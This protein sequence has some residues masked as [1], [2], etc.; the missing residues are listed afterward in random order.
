MWHI[1]GNASAATAA[2]TDQTVL[3]QM[4]QAEF[5]SATEVIMRFGFVSAAGV[6]LSAHTG[7][8]IG[9]AWAAVYLA[10]QG[11]HYGFLAWCRGPE[12]PWQVVVSHIGYALRTLV[13]VSLPLWLMTRPDT[14]LIMAGALGLSALVVFLLWRKP[15]P[16]S[17]LPIDVA[18]HGLILT[19]LLWH[20]LP[21]AAELSAKIAIAVSA[22]AQMT[23]FAMALY[24]TTDMRQRLSDA[25]KRGVEAEKLQAIGQ[26]SSGIAHD[27]NNILTVIRGNL[28][29]HAEVT[30]PE[31]RD[32]LIGD[33]QLAAVRA[34]TLVAQLLSF[35]R[36]A[37]LLPVD[38][39][40]HAVIAEIA[41][42]AARLLPPGISVLT[43]GMD[44]PMTL[45]VDADRLNA[46]LLNLVLNARDAINE[47]RP[48]TG[49][50]VISADTVDAAMV[51][52]VPRSLGHGPHIRFAV[53][54][55]G[56]GM[57]AEQ[58]S[59][60]VEPFFTTKPVGKGSGLGLA[61]AKS[62]AEQSG[63]AMTITSRPGRTVVA[64]YLPSTPA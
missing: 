43:E 63:G 47:T 14:A 5:A 35:S 56:P 23:Y 62:F 28:E 25:A 26:L 57:T 54:D 29:L 27:F 15:P 33:A 40:A 8:A 61:S 59:R 46:A 36:R 19:V 11:M 48:G 2:T 41:A 13:F 18:V 22:I 34:S 3:A 45:K 30:D 60:A 53:T 4:R 7:N 31:E 37:P 49:R 64:L 6:A 12:Q 38:S 24:G 58:A 42:M 44:R 1:R 50:I 9:I 51:G 20:F 55:D 21:Q 17:L 52:D 32:R 10:S 16:R 39:D